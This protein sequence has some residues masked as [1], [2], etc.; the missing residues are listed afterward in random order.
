MSLKDDLLKACSDVVNATWDPR[1]GRKVPSVDDVALK[2]GAVELEG[3]VV[4]A[5]L[6][7]S[8]GL[9]EN[10]KIKF[11]AHV[12]RVFLYVSSQLI[13]QCGGTIR[14]FDGDRVMGIFTGDKHVDAAA[15]AA[16][17]I[18][19][20]K[21]NVIIPSLSKAWNMADSPWKFNYGVGLDTSSLTV[22]RA[23]VRG[24]NDL[25]WLGS[26]A[27]HSAKLSN[28]RDVG[29]TTFATDRFVKA[30][31]YQKN[32]SGTPTWV[33]SADRACWMSSSHIAFT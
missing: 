4:Y 6:A 33:T 12:T 28:R 8:T 7:D 3:S 15:K 30:T 31:I 18:T 2:E 10:S 32:D 19:Y 21:N 23:G 9:V 22:I 27:N 1:D 25:V 24:D 29:Y 16:F 26:C 20:A 5:D 13:K 14:S 11:A 17:M